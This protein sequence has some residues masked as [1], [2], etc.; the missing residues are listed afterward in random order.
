ML[1]EVV[2]NIR[3]QAPLR[4]VESPSFP[5]ADAAYRRAQS[6]EAAHEMEEARR[7]YLLAKDL[8]GMR[9]RAAEDINR[10]IHELADRFR[11][12]VVPMIGS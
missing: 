1:S 4:S 2:S 8:D 9:F 11:L 5:S 12:P 3:D 7:H 10:I 6:L